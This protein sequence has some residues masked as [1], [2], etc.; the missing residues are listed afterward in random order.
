LA[1]RG[2]AVLRYDKRTYAYSRTLDAANITVEQEVVED[3]LSAIAAVRSQVRIDPHK[4]FLAG[5]S[6]GGFLA[7]EIASR[8][9][10]VRGIAI[11][12]ANTQPIDRVLR[13]QLRFL[14]NLD[15]VHR[16]TTSAAYDSANAL[17]DS[18]SAHTL[19]VGRMLFG[20][21]T[22]Y[23]YELMSREPVRIVMAMTIP[24]LVVGGGSDYQV[25]KDEFRS[26]QVALRR[27][28]NVTFHFYLHM[29]HL[30][31]PSTGRIGPL[32][33]EGTQ[34]HVC[35]SLVRD[36]TTWIKTI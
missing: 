21:P 3:A 15:S 31:L 14:S 32:D 10:D 19:P 29:N 33:Y 35:P 22:Q 1:T 7:P 36:I 17:I 2:I 4:I 9:G 5:H 12:A 30:L 27:R 13:S 26:W 6:L 11:L 25:T 34:R 28:T 23:Y 24:V 16:T 8:A 20:A 18:L